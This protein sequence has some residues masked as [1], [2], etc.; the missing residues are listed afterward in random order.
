MVE[1]GKRA[2]G[3]RKTLA[4]LG[5]DRLPK[6][7][8]LWA[9]SFFAKRGPKARR[10]GQK[11]AVYSHMAMWLKWRALPS[12]ERKFWQDRMDTLRNERAETI[13]RNKSANGVCRKQPA[14]EGG[15]NQA[16]TNVAQGWA[17][18]APSPSDETESDAIVAPS[19]F[20]EVATFPWC[21]ERS[22][23]ARK[24]ELS[25]RRTLP[26]GGGTYGLCMAVVDRDTGEAFCVKIAKD[27]DVAE[28]SAEALR[29]EYDVLRRC[30]H[31]NII[32]PHALITIPCAV[33]RLAMLLPRCD[34][35]L[36]AWLRD[37]SAAPLGEGR[38]DKRWETSCLL[39]VARALAHLHGIGFLHL[40]V[41]AENVLVEA[42]A[43][44]LL[45]ADFGMAAAYENVDHPSADARM[46]QT[47]VYRPWD[48]FHAAQSLVRLR[49][50]H[51]VWAFGCLV[52]EVAQLHPGIWREGRAPAHLFSGVNMRILG[53]ADLRGTWL[54]R[55]G[56]H[57]LP[58]YKPLVEYCLTLPGISSRQKAPYVTMSGALQFLHQM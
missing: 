52:Y 30:W 39:Q 20:G 32:R 13:R 43:G 16:A 19:I 38:V 23:A 57:M 54:A 7:R 28:S 8:E 9:K 5:V 24:L 25:S 55:I 51:D 40:D 22:G 4:D 58:S 35:N 50:R 27:G 48:L 6:A 46:I 47:E 56:S 18:E 14:T 11:T 44:R 42:S 26:L 2:S 3:R 36:K 53:R 10:M 34:C 49:P 12:V 29:L 21:D 1:A 37:A 33:E 41:K 17:V 15:A 45:L 31:P